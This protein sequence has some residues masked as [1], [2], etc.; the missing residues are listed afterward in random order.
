MV[1]RRLPMFKIEKGYVFDGPKGKAGLKDLFDSGRQLIIYHF[2]FDPA[3]N[4]RPPLDFPTEAQLRFSLAQTF[5]P[6]M[7]STV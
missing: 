6:P 5:A 7:A 3:W 1:R 4:I 2:M